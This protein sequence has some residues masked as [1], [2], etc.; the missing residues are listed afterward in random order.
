MST[1]RR[2][3]ARSLTAGLFL[4]AALASGCGKKIAA[5][6]ETKC[7]AADVQTCTDTSAT[8]E[9]TAEERGCESEFEDYVSCLDAKGTCTKGVLDGATACATEIKALDACLQ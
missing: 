6:C 1:P 3:T 7:A 5:V 4:T 8:A 9:A 2:F